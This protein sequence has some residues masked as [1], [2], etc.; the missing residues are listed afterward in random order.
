MATARLWNAM[1][2]ANLFRS[3][4]LVMLV[5]ILVSLAINVI[6]QQGAFPWTEHVPGIVLIACLLGCPVAFYV[7]QA[8][9]RD[10][11][12]ANPVEATMVY[13]GRLTEGYSGDIFED[14]HAMIVAKR[15][16]HFPGWRRP[17][18]PPSGIPR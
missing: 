8:F 3:I 9:W 4:V 7:F 14:A 5:S 16:W 13:G 12:H 6:M 10:A 18:A 11:L 17:F 15:Y 2:R 1:D